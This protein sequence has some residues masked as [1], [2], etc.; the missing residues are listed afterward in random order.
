[1]RLAP[2][3]ILHNNNYCV[4]ESEAWEQSACTETLLRACQALR[5]LLSSP[6]SIIYHTYMLDWEDEVQDVCDVCLPFCSP[7]CPTE[8]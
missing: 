2:L 6:Y 5:K 3:I 8:K 4:A 1:M 7:S